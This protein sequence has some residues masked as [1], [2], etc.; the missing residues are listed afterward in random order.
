M[1]VVVNVVLLWLMWLIVL[2]LIWGLE[3]LNLVLVILNFFL[4]Y[5]GYFIFRLESEIYVLFFK[6]I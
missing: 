4:V 2:M 5:I 3:C 1:I 6:F